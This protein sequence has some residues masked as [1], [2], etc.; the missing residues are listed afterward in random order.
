VVPFGV[1]STDKQWR[2]AGAARVAGDAAA[3]TAAEELAGHTGRAVEDR[4]STH[5]G[6]ADG[7]GAAGTGD[8]GGQ[9]CRR[10]ALEAVEVGAQIASWETSNVSS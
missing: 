5:W 9:P 6:L 3:H 4:D 10:V 1:C 8:V 2:F 7:T